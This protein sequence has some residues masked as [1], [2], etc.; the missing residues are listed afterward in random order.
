MRLWDRLTAVVRLPS[1]DPDDREP[2]YRC[3]SC[4]ADYERKHRACPQ[5]NGRFVVELDPETEE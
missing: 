5:C 4:G 3:L 2:R 1:I